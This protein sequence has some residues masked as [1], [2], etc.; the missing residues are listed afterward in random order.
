MKYPLTTNTWDG[1]EQ[2]AI[3]EVC[4]NGQI[5]CS[6][7]VSVYEMYLAKHLRS[8]HAIC[9][10]SGG[11]ANLLLLAAMVETGRLKVGDHVAVPA[12]GWSTTYAPIAQLGLVPVYADVDETWNIHVCK[13]LDAVVQDGKVKAVFAVSV[14]GNGLSTD[15]VDYCKR[16]GVLLMEDACE[17]FD[18][19]TVGVPRTISTY[20][21]HHISTGE[22]GAILVEDSDFARVLRSM[23][24]HGWTRE[25][26]TEDTFRSK[27]TFKYAG[28]SMRPTEIV[29]AVGQLQLEKYF[30]SHRGGFRD[31]RL[32]NAELFRMLFSGNE[33]YTL[34]VP[35]PGAYHSY[36]GF[37]ILLPEGTDMDEIYRYLKSEGIESRPVICGDWTKQPI[38]DSKI[39]NG[40]ISGI[41][42]TDTVCFGVGM[43]RKI[44]DRGIFFGNY[45]TDLSKELIHLRKTLDKYFEV[46]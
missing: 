23:R 31:R 42:A 43:S 5:T 32:E 24:A 7:S 33:H 38:K 20:F 6:S 35:T 13:D 17:S 18:A 3:E 37:G 19:G 41:Y 45:G 16:N 44:H 46:A 9:V 36:Y 12:V 39:F 11:S 8:R 1:E 25:T 28:F 2:K 15:L 14:L 4:R 26:E 34:Q 10:N 40:S 21:S 22:G 27:F 29:G 30:K